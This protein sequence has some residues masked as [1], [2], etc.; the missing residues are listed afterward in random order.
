MTYLKSVFLIDDNNED[1]HFFALCADEL[2]NKIHLECEKDL[3][4][5]LDKLT[6][7]RR[8]L[9]DVIFLDWNMP[10]QSGE[11]CLKEFR[12]IPRLD[13]VPIIVLS[14]SSA[15]QDKKTALL[16]GAFLIISKPV[17][18]KELT[19]LLKGIFVGSWSREIDTR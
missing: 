18:L 8:A 16:L 14:A 19:V 11:R 3:G 13:P 2:D 4:R 9:P 12:K 7:E 10:E 5:A 17:S 15:D 6:D 1:R